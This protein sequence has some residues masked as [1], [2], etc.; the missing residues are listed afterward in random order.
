MWPIVW[1]EA[2]LIYIYSFEEFVQRLAIKSDHSPRGISISAIDEIKLA[3]VERTNA[4]LEARVAI[5]ATL[6]FSLKSPGS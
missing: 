1:R 6:T 2:I 3:M 4:E 5:I